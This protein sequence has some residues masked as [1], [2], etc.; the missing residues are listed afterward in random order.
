MKRQ[1]IQSLLKLNAGFALGAMLLLGA[2]S[3]VVMFELHDAV[4]RTTTS[5]EAVRIQMDADMMHD[6][7]RGDV[8]E[9]IKLQLMADS[10]GFKPVQEAVLEHGDRLLKNL[11]ENRANVEDT[12]LKSSID[13]VTVVAGRYVASALKIVKEASISVPTD[14]QWNNF[15]ADFE[16][17]EVS[18]EALSDQ[19][20]QQA[21]AAKSRSEIVVQL[22]VMGISVLLLFSLVVVF[23]MVRRL[24]SSI[25]QPLNSLVSTVTRVDKEGNLALRAEKRHDNEI[26]D[27][28]GAFN[29]L[30]GSLQHIVQ[31]VKNSSQELRQASEVLSQASD[32]STHSSQA[33]SDAASSVAAAVEQLSVS[34]ASISSQAQ[35]AD[36]ASRSSLSLAQQAGKSTDLAGNEMRNISAFVKQSAHTMVELEGQVRGISEIAGTIRS[37]AQ[38]TNLLALNAAIEA[39]RAGEQGRG[40]AVVADEVRVLAERT[41]DS[42]LKIGSIIDAIQTGTQIAVEQMQN[43][44]GQVEHGVK[45]TEEVIGQ[46]QGVTSH[47]Q[48]TSAAITQISESLREQDAAG[49]DIARSVERV[50]NVSEENHHVARETAGVAERLAQLSAQLEG[51]VAR[52]SAGA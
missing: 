9:A 15:M 21:T 14:D 8:L 6:A 38:Q 26:G 46:I 19:L 2:G 32:K 48:R 22:S 12:A 30:M 31:G 41:A 3:G 10:S 51:Q 44:V 49:Q 4:K 47:S 5:F 34:V 28:I 25:Q 1:S 16:S 20:G 40:F 24:G 43:G 17:L 45:I 7:L 11:K 13:E 27:V 23:L 50:A 29:G 36:Q 52:F 42:T 37:I 33:N 35:Q 18:M 39:A